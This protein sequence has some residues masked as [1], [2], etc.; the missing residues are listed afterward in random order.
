M[1]WLYVTLISY[2]LFALSSITDRYLLAG[3]LQK[4]RAFAFYTGIVGGFATLLIFVDFVIPSTGFVIPFTDFIVPPA[5]VGFFAPAP[6]IIFVSFVSGAAKIMGLYLLYRAIFH[7]NVSTAVPMVGAL[8]PLSTLFFA[9][10]LAGESFVITIQGVLALVSLII[11]SILVSLQITK[12]KFSFSG[13]V[14]TSAVGAA[15]F[16]GFSFV[17]AKIIFDSIGF[18]NGLVWI[19]WGGVLFA[20]SLLIFEET[21]D[22][23]FE[24]NPMQQKNV[25]APVLIG[26][27]AGGV[28]G[29]LQSYAVS[30]AQLV[31]VAFINALG[32]VQ[33]LFL[34]FF[35]FI[36]S[37]RDPEILK[38]HFT[39]AS[40]GM[41]FAGTLF[42]GIGL[43][44]LVL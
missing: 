15:V 8:T 42:I 23:V 31:Q 13:V 25:W 20:L 30:I 17:S 40:L 9:Y 38:E 26:K 41:R 12:H 4:P 32:G 34:L 43:A 33:Y 27:V 3:P 18:L 44:L 5:P 1:L 16:L 19:S 39:H 14:G 2:F 24:K 21:R 10:I 29:F 35:A 37:A 11:G 22:L 36:V 6:G 7:G 28:G